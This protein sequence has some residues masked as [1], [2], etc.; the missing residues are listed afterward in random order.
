LNSA[1]QKAQAA[2]QKFCANGAYAISAQY[3]QSLL[4]TTINDVAAHKTSIDNG[5]FLRPYITNASVSGGTLQVL[6]MNSMRLLHESRWWSTIS[7]IYH[8][9]KDSRDAYELTT[10]AMTQL[11]ALSGHAGRCYM[12]HWEPFT[13]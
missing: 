4:E 13:N 1:K 6:G 11:D 2:C 12:A 10:T 9:S 7:T 8:R 3:A 5:G